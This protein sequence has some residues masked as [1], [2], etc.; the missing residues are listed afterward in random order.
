MKT[1]E[2][3]NKIHQLGTD[4]TQGNKRKP[5][6]LKIVKHR[7]EII[8]SVNFNVNELLLNTSNKLSNK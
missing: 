7:Q 2:F 3:R 6:L 1:H 5:G 4:G 8:Y